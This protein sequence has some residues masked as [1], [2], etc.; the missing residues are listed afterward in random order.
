M[1]L[2]GMRIRK[3][4]CA[5]PFLSL[6]LWPSMKKHKSISCIP[7]TSLTLLTGSA[8]RS[9]DGREVEKL[10]RI[11]TLCSWTFYLWATT[12]LLVPQIEIIP[13]FWEYNH[14]RQVCSSYNLS[15]VPVFQWNPWTIV[16]LYALKPSLPLP[17]WAS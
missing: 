14:V 11:V 12:Y 8:K 1:R 3:L 4:V 16:N 5:F 7:T 15:T 10:A 17:G 6:G 13:S 2:F 9:E